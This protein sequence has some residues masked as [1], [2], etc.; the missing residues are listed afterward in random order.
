MDLREYRG[1]EGGREDVLSHEMQ[2]IPCWRD[3]LDV[4]LCLELHAI[5]DTAW[6]TDSVERKIMNESGTDAVRGSYT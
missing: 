5:V 4:I 2:R 6:G 1:N 3:R